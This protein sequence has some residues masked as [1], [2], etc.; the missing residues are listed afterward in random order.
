[1]L[2]FRA[3]SGSIGWFGSVAVDG[4]TSVSA[5]MNCADASSCVP[6]VIC[7]FIP[8]S[9]SILKSFSLPLTRAT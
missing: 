7:V 3:T 9:G 6:N 5:S 1:M 8:V 2:P 4:N